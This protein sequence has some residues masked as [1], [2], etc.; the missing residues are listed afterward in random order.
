AACSAIAAA[1]SISSEGASSLEGS[2]VGSVI[3]F[4]TDSLIEGGQGQHLL[5]PQS[6]LAVVCAVVAL[7]HGHTSDMGGNRFRNVDRDEVIHLQAHEV[8]DR[9]V[10]MCEFRREFHVGGTYF[11]REPVGPALVD[12][13]RSAFLQGPRKQVSQGLDHGIGQTNIQLAAGCAEFDMEG[14]YHHDLE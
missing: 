11:L 14:R 2:W 9:H 3:F 4:G 1:Q 10:D 6:H 13:V 12:L 5:N 8:T 7:K